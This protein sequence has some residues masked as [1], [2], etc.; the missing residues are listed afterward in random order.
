MIG[1]NLRM[2]EVTAAIALVQLRRGPEIIAGRVKQAEALRAE[3][4][5]I[6]EGYVPPLYRMPAFAKFARPCPVAEDLHDR[7]LFYFENCAHDITLA[8]AEQI[9]AAFRKAAENIL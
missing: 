2:T 3:G 1:L 8:Q 9:G 5:P 4:V 7:R 6:V